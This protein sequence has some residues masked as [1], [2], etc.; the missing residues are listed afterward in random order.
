[1]WLLLLYSTCWGMEWPSSKLKKEEIDWLKKNI[2]TLNLWVNQ[3]SQW[4]KLDNMIFTEHTDFPIDIE[5]AIRSWLFLNIEKAH[6][7]LPLRKME[8]Q[9]GLM[10]CHSYKLHLLYLNRPGCTEYNTAGQRKCKWEL[11]LLPSMKCII[12]QSIGKV[13][14][15]CHEAADENGTL[16]VIYKLRLAKYYLIP[17]PILLS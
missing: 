1:M 7:Q 10:Q 2:C 5:D 11:G 3:L 4:S 14:K 12:S 15:E 6:C 16:C 9:C 8:I 13:F 17:T